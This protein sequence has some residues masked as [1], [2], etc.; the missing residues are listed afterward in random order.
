MRFQYL[1]NRKPKYDLY[2]LDKYRFISN[3]N[4]IFKF[5][6]NQAEDLL[7]QYLLKDS[8][9]TDTN[10]IKLSYLFL[11]DIDKL[12]DFDPQA[13]EIFTAHEVNL[14][15]TDKHG[16]IKVSYINGEKILDNLSLDSFVEKYDI[17]DQPNIVLPYVKKGLLG[18]IKRKL[19]KLKLKTI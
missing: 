11:K 4:E 8:D 7:S 5:T 16:N 9:Q 12:I 10:I 14:L 18:L 3:A 1:D 2:N 13:I 6:D 15:Y 17:K 19:E